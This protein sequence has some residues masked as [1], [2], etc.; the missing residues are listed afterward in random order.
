MKRGSRDSLPSRA[1]GIKGETRSDCKW[2]WVLGGG[3]GNGLKLTVVTARCLWAS[4]GPHGS[5]L[6]RSELCP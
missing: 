2:V 3:G 1:E 5:R 4:Q 6:Q